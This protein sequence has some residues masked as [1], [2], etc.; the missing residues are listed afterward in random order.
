MTSIDDDDDWED[1][2]KNDYKKEDIGVARLIKDPTTKNVIIDDYLVT[3]VEG[4]EH[5]T[6]SDN[7]EKDN[8]TAISNNENAKKMEE[9]SPVC[10]D[11]DTSTP[12]SSNEESSSP[13]DDSEA[14]HTFFPKV[15]SPKDK[16]RKRWTYLR[17]TT[18][19]AKKQMKFF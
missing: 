16:Q 10:S 8:K 18:D 2:S 6:S 4:K 14:I 13:S 17:S 3:P 7:L 19:G 9:K 5:V 12:S 11:K 1:L 15:P